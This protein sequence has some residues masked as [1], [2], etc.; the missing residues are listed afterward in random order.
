MRGWQ[1]HAL[2]QRR[3]WCA[4]AHVKLV[5]EQALVDLVADV[6]QRLPVGVGEQP[7]DAEVAGVV[8]GRLGSEGAGFFVVLLDLA[9]R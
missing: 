9:A 4:L 2:K 8:D 7:T 5:I 1:H 3:V 6:D